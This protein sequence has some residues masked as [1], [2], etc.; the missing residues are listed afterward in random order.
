[1][2][3]GIVTRGGGRIYIHWK[4]LSIFQEIS[5]FQ[6]FFQ[7]LQLLCYKPKRILKIMWPNRS[8]MQETS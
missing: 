5:L 8:K 2:R 7:D 3:N 1:M 6:I 4:F